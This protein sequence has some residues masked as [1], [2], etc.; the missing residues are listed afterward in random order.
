MYK[1]CNHYV[2]LGNSYEIH[3]VQMIVLE[4]CCEK[5]YTIETS[6]HHHSLY[7]HQSH[8]S[9]PHFSE[10]ATPHQGVQGSCVVSA[11]VGNIMQRVKI[12]MIYLRSFYC[13]HVPLRVRVLIYGNILSQFQYEIVIC[14]TEYVYYF[15][16][17]FKNK[18]FIARF[19]Y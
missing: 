6:T 11:V 12:R 4:W 8:P 13:F 16:Q 15:R 2:I 5:L 1:N 19:F 3:A 14:S 10:T 9:F 17:H 7:E 18:D